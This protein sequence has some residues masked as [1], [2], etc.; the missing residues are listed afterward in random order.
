MTGLSGR[1]ETFAHALD[2]RVSTCHHHARE[3]ESSNLSLL[4][5]VAALT[6]GLDVVQRI[7]TEPLSIKAASVSLGLPP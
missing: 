3:Y 7:S 2:E 4:L 6:G 5:V 1:D